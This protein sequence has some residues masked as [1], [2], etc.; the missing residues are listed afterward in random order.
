MYFGWNWLLFFVFAVCVFFFCDRAHLSTFILFSCASEIC[1]GLRQPGTVAALTMLH[2][3]SIPQWLGW[4]QQNSMSVLRCIYERSVFYV[5]NTTRVCLN[6][7]NYEFFLMNSVSLF[8]RYSGSCECIFPRCTK[9]LLPAHSFVFLS[10]C[11]VFTFLDLAM[12]SDVHI[13][14]PY[15]SCFA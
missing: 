6:S 15:Y 5:Q 2:S 11:L 13:K 10:I 3:N 12:P 8:Q 4:R 9:N 7:H 1:D 14:F